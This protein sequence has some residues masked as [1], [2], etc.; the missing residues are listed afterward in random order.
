MQSH[1]DRVRWNLV[2]DVDQRLR[3]RMV[4]FRQDEAA[5][6]GLLLTCLRQ[7]AR[8]IES[9]D[10]IVALNAQDRQWLAD[11]WDRIANEAEPGK[12]VRLAPEPIDSLAGLRVTSADNRIRIDHS[13]EGR[14]E[15]LRGEVQRVILERLLPAGLETGNLFNG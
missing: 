13:F 15:R 2:T 8:Q 7:A 11:D 1:L 4:T 6:R 14:L 10:L 5:Y 12:S 9:D 3:E